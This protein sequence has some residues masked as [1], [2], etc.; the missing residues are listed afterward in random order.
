MHMRERWCNFC[1]I[2]MKKKNDDGNLKF[3][4]FVQMQQLGLWVHIFSRL[5]IFNA[6]QQLS[7]SH[8]LKPFY[9]MTIGGL[10]SFINQ[11]KLVQHTKLKKTCQTTK[12]ME[13][14]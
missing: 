4:F 11:A 12:I 14:F 6:S 7:P 5:K 2:S 13:E 10:M 3:Q 9:E 8:N 1:R